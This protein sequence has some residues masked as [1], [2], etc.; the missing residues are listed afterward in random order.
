MP[1]CTS[2]RA[3]TMYALALGAISFRSCESLA[4]RSAWRVN[5]STHRAMATKAACGDHQRQH[6]GG[7]YRHRQR[8]MAAHAAPRLNSCD[9]PRTSKW[10]RAGA[11]L[12]RAS[13]RKRAGLR[14][15]TRA[16]RHR[17][18]RLAGGLGD[19][20]SRRWRI[21]AA[22]VH[23]RERGKSSRRALI[24]TIKASYD[25]RGV[26]GGKHRIEGLSRAIIIA[27]HQT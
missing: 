19:T 23:H 25:H 27:Q 21:C 15:Q 5:Q 6:H 4:K 13:R 18:G 22:N 16:Q 17:G 10:R 1:I 3:G 9:A 20:S 14:A 24:A 11:L 8:V 7:A 2:A 12:T 26:I